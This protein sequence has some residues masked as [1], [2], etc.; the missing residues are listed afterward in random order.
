MPDS[1]SSASPREHLGARGYLWS[2]SASECG[3]SLV[4]SCEV[5]QWDSDEPIPAKELERGVAGAHGLL[6]LLTDHVDKRLLD[7]AG[8]CPGQVWGAFQ[9]CLGPVGAHSL[10][11][12]APH[13]GPW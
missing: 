11:R 13:T 7:A 5:E 4:F 8:V 3:L 12:L 1:D 2:A 9:G 10:L 6:C